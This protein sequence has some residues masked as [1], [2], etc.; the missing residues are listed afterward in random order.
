MK[1]FDDIVIREPGDTDEGFCRSCLY[2]D[3]WTHW[4][5]QSESYGDADGDWSCDHWVGKDAYRI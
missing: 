3:P 4:C 1:K 5:D 2:W